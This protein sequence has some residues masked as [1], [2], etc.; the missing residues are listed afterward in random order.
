MLD[1]LI[2]LPSLASLLDTILAE[3][4]QTSFP[5]LDQSK[6]QVNFY[7]VESGKNVDPGD[8]PT[9]RWHRSL[10]LSDAVLQYYRHQRWPSGQ[11]H[12]FSHPKRASASVD[13][14]HWE[15]AVRTASGQLI[16]LLFRRM[17]LY[18][19]ASTTGDGASRR[20]F[21]SRAIREQA[22]ADILLKREA[23]II[24]PDQ[25]QALHA[26][27]QTVA[28]AIRRPTLETVRLWEH[29]A[30]YV[31][32]AGSLMISHPSA[33]LYT[34]TQGLQVLQDYQDLKATLISKFSAT[35][36]E[37]ELYGL[38]GLEERNRFIG[39][40]QPN[41]SGEVIHG[42]IFNVLFEAIITKQRQNIEYA[43]QVFRHS[44]GSV[45]IHA[46]FDKALDIR[47]M[48]S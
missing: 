26:M 34:P 39:F 8:D 16:P 4:L 1:E 19:E 44:D 14:Q 23:Q 17:E 47:A 24:P 36:H 18:W 40:D 7:S 6:T 9:R 11:V 21:F 37:D 28:E 43:L 3:L 33:Y 42:Q 27:I 41:V 15:T 48:I 20:V 32:L 31:E 29:E 10:S 46:L 45:D 12:E 2:E 38:L 35:G 30:N 22:R 13:Q 25:W 5:G